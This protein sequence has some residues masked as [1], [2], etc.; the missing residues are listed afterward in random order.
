VNLRRDAG[1]MF[2]DG[3][4]I[5]DFQPL[6]NTATPATMSVVLTGTRFKANDLIYVNGVH[7]G[8]APNTSKTFRSP[9]LV[10]VSFPVVTDENLKVTVV[11]D[12]VAVSRSVPNPAVLKI[13]SSG[14][15]FYEPAGNNKPG[16]LVLKIEGQGFPTST[17]STITVGGARCERVAYTENKLLVRML[18]P[19]LPVVVTIS[20]GGN[21]VSAAVEK[22]PDPK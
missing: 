22:F 16:V 11:Q 2:G 21:A 1:T 20:N 13:T 14:V 10:L 17:C 3:L 12:K 5:T 19:Q 15:A 4:T 8:V 7:I 9:N 18:D 6:R